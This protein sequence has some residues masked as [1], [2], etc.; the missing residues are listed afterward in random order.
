MA[1]NLYVLAEMFYPVSTGLE[2]NMLNTYKHMSFRGWNIEVHT[3]KVN[4]VNRDASTG[5]SE[6]F[7][8]KIF[9][10]N[11]YGFSFIPF[12]IRPPF[13][14]SGTIVFH[15]FIILPHIFLYSYALILKLLGLK[16]CRLI[17]SSHGLFNYNSSIYPGL[18]MKIRKL[19]DRSI[20]V[21]LINRTVDAI[22]AVSEVEA[23]G[24]IAQGIRADLI[25]EIKNGIEEFA[26]DDIDTKVDSDFKEKIKKLDDYIIQVARIDRVKNQVS[27]IVAL[28]C[29]KN[30][31]TK[32][33]FL[34]PVNSV[35][36]KTE[37]D[38]LISNL[39]LKD[40][41]I[42]WGTEVGYQKYYLVKNAKMLVHM[43]YAEGFCNAVHEAMSQGV[44]CI[45]AK[46]S[47]QEKLIKNGVNGFSEE[48]D[49]YEKI[50]HRID[51][52]MDSSNEEEL[53]LMRK[54]NINFAAG[55]TWESVS[56]KVEKLYSNP[57]Y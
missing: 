6:I 10:H 26:F 33:I 40:R 14:K 18:R 54:N 46:G 5:H 32:L 45:V 50:A 20:G 17:F 28:A 11:F 57:D 37:L 36:Y 27:A 15:D 13:M 9:R 52:A 35:R 49:D 7:G 2:I 12:F 1:K 22:R 47:A 56:F 8:L 19:I 43:A 53:E 16:R 30:K 23:R 34:G 24:L 3:T 55:H 31:K 21:F 29:A 39:S 25:T 44:V 4:D 41:V 51:W 48:A 38:R 42:F